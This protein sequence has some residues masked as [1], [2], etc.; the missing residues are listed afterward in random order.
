[1]EQAEGGSRKW[2]KRQATVYHSFDLALPN[3]FWITIKAD[4]EIENRFAE[5]NKTDLQGSSSQAQK[6][7]SLSM[8]FESSLASH[9]VHFEWCVEGWASFIDN[10]ELDIRQKLK[11]IT[12][13]PVEH[14]QI[15]SAIRSRS[16]YEK[17]QAHLNLEDIK[18][19]ENKHSWFSKRKTFDRNEPQSKG[20]ITLNR[21]LSGISKQTTFDTEKHGTVRSPTQPISKQADIAHLDAKDSVQ[22]FIDSE[23]IF[24]EFSVKGYQKLTGLSTALQ[25][26]RVALASNLQ[27]LDGIVDTYQSFF[28]SDECAQEIKDHCQKSMRLFSRRLKCKASELRAEDS[29]A[30]SLISQLQDSK[31]LYESILQYRNIKAN[32]AMTLHAH[33]AS[34]RMEAVGE[35]TEKLTSSMHVITT[36]TLLLLPGTFLGVS[37]WISRSCSRCCS[38]HCQSLFSTDIISRGEKGIKLDSVLGPLF[39]EIC[40]PMMVVSLIAWGFYMYLKRKGSRRRKADLEDGVVEGEG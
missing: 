15:S 28:E 2:T 34:L 32:E 31:P 5:K 39:L 26:T 9:L 22:R 33:Y 13:A 7:Q 1:M 35:R 23:A 37:A 6:L 38:K 18:T 16:F 25:E 19:L 14:N 29:R 20:P 21:L 27:A 10:K 30:A 11:I 3:Q 8:A 36:F 4:Q 40:L 24:K 17:A 12:A